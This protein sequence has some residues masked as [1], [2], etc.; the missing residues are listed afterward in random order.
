MNMPAGKG[1]NEGLFSFGS[2]VIVLLLTFIFGFVSIVSIANALPRNEWDLEEDSKV[3]TPISHDQN[4]NHIQGNNSEQELGGPDEGV[5]DDDHLSGGNRVTE[6]HSGT[7]MGDW[8]DYED[9]QPTK[10]SDSEDSERPLPQR[11]KDYLDNKAKIAP[12]VD[13]LENEVGQLNRMLSGYALRYRA[14][15]DNPVTLAQ[16][17][18][19]IVD[20]LPSED[21]SNLKD[22]PE[23]LKALLAEIEVRSGVEMDTPSQKGITSSEQSEDTGRFA[24]KNTALATV[25]D[26]SPAQC[27][28]GEDTCQS[29]RENYSGSR[30]LMVVETAAKEYSPERKVLPDSARD[31]VQGNPVVGYVQKLLSSRKE[32][33]DTSAGKNTALATVADISPAQCQAGEDTCQSPRENYSGSRELMVVETAAKEYSPE[34]KVL[35][36]SARDIVQGN[37]VVGYVQKLLS[38]REET[39]DTS[40]GKNTALATVADISPAQCQAGEDTCQSPRENYSGSRELMVVETAAKEYSPERKVLPDSAR[41]IVQGNPV[42][43]YVQKLLSSRKETEDTSAG[44]NT[45][46]ATVA[47]ISP[48]QCQ[49]GEDTCQSPRESYSGSRELMVVETAAKEYSPERKVLPDSAR[50]IVQGNPVVGYVQKLLSSRKETEDTSA[51]KNTALATVADISPAQCQAGEDTCQ[52]PRE[53]YSGSRELMVVETAAKEYSPERKVLP[54]SAR[55]IVQGNPVVGYVQKLLSSRKET[56]DTSAGKNTALATVADI[57]P[58]QCQAGEDTCQSPRESYSGSRELMVVE[59]AA[60]EYSPERKVLPDSARDIVQGNPVVGYV[61]KLLSSRKET[62]DT[63]A[64]KNTALA[65]VADISPAQCQ[66]DEDTCQSPRESY[67]GSRELMVVETAAKE[68][69]PE[70]KVLPDSARDI[71]QGNPVVGYVQKLLSSRKETEDT[72]AQVRTQR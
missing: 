12:A 18:D 11:A 5:E 51:G 8:E 57:S 14:V 60:K 69:S 39:E 47:D 62:E 58:A 33:E 29:P 64:G 3:E 31:I 49:A 42:V 44:K 27:Q 17:M 23:Q 72:S 9:I 2:H 36:D 6:V 1:R 22:N 28:A 13:L 48:A 24:G 38:S 15:K 68:Y 4:E 67:S 65:T 53:S 21:F 50:D 35:P 41:D 56:E 59:T 32:T 70:R 19:E 20:V 37:P 45:A 26:I 25:A 71:V 34:R 54:D 52:S 7:L 30:E 16:L 46:L 10:I 40:A 61:Q 43:G 66:A 55:D 63:S